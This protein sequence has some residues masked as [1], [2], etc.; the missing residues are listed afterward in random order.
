MNTTNTITS[1]VDCISDATLADLLP[2]VDT[3]VLLR[4][5]DRPAIRS[6][7]TWRLSADLEVNGKR[8]TITTTTHDE[9]LKVHF[10]DPSEWNNMSEPTMTEGEAG[11]AILALLFAANEDELNEAAEEEEEAITN[12]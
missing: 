9:D 11:E 2:I 4:H 1:Y 6:Y 5:I 12:N 10:V 8:M 7:G 3:T